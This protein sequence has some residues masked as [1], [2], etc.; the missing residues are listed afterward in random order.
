[1]TRPGSEETAEPMQAADEWLEA[2]LDTERRGDSSPGSTRRTG[3][4]RTRGVFGGL[5][6]VDPV[7]A[8]LLR[9]SHRPSGQHGARHSPRGSV[10]TEEITPLKSD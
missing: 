4:C 6:A 10:V 2:I 9:F 7:P 3:L 8:N 1:M 5:R